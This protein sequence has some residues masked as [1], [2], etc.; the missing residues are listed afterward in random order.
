MTFPAGRYL[1]ISLIASLLAGL[2]FLTGLPGDFVLDD[3]PNIVNNDALKLERLDADSL[4][5]VATARQMSGNMRV[6]PTLTFAV[7][8][9]RAGSMDPAT[10]KTTSIL[11]HALTTCALAW[12]FLQVLLTAGVTNDRARLLSLAL[13]LAWAIHPLQVSA[14]LYTVQRMQTMGTMFLVLA[15]LAYLHARRAQID[16]RSGRKG[17]LFAIMAW[18]LAMGCKEDTVLLPAYTLALELTV[19]RFAAANP[20]LAARLRKGY[21]FATAAGAAFFLLWA[22]PQFWVSER[23][24]FRD[25]NTYERLLTQGRVLCMYLSQ[26]LLP[27]PQDMPFYYDWLQPSRGLVQPWTT[28]PSLLAISGLLGSAW[29]L[30]HRMPLYALGVLLFF[31][32]H[33]I[34]SNI[35]LLELAFEHRNHFALIGAVLAIGSLLAHASMRLRLRIRTQAVLC[36]LIL[37][38]LASATL[39]RTHVWADKTRFAQVSTQLAPHSARVWFGLCIEYFKAGGEAIHSNPNLDKAIDSCSAGVAAA[40]YALNTSATLLVLKTLRGDITQQ[41]WDRY[42]HSMNTVNMSW[43]NQRAAMILAYYSRK[44][45]DLNR[46]EMLKSLATLARRADIAPFNSASLGYF[47]MND[48]ANPDQAMPYFIAAVSAASPRDPF[49]WQL[50]SE[51]KAKGRPDLAEKIE[52]LGK[53][54][55]GKPMANP[56]PGH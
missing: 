45:V 37:I 8:Y 32:A 17:I 41:D 52:N 43:D 15:L 20:V 25:F 10:F 30:R 24:V 1:L 47:I 21:A 26:I 5:E 51:L 23:P 13:A 27:L 33:F 16:G 34:T 54:R 7:D 49:P 11:I 29:W 22:V 2:L 31:G 39:M 36:T 6:L 18:F 14:V 9:W 19:L 46:Q 12:F 28:L 42:Q 40:P 35:I 50:A 44:G 38:A 56:A 3:V 55:I 48:L 53:A 4:Y